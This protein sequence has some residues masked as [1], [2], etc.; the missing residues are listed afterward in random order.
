[1]TRGKRMK[2]N[3][4][5]KIIFYFIIYFLLFFVLIYSGIKIYEWTGIKIKTMK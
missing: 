2:K 4:N 3:N 5:T 1:M